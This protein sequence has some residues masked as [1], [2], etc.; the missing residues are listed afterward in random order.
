M[1]KI[2]VNRLSSPLISW[3]LIFAFA[4][5]F[6]PVVLA[7]ETNETNDAE[8]TV[9]TDAVESELASENSPP[10]EENDTEEVEPVEETP[11]D[12][13][14]LK[15]TQVV[16]TANGVVQASIEDI[17]TFKQSYK[18]YRDRIE[19]FRQETLQLVELQHQEGKSAIQSQYS[20][21]LMSL[22]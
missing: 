2:H 5:G 12:F 6:S 18:R 16:E 15:E 9:E 17:A 20:D 13:N 4:V 8:S 14:E 7:Q 21:K 22:Q 19:E 11:Q 3:S 1:T 10:V